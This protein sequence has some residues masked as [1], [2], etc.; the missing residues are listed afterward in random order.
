MKHPKKPPSLKEVLEELTPDEQIELFS[1]S[2]PVNSEYHHW[3][4]LRHLGPPE[5]LTNKQ[6][7]CMLKLQ[8]SGQAR[9]VPLRDN[10]G[11]AFTYYQTEKMSKAVHEIDLG[12]GGSIG[13]PEPVMNENTKNYYYVNSLIQ[14]AIT[15]S[16]LE[17]AAVTR[18]VAKEMIQSNR[19]PLGVDERMIVNNYR[20]MERLSEWKEMALTPVL[21]MEI[22]ELMTDGT[23]EKPD[24]SGRLRN[25]GEVVEIVDQRDGEVM[26]S[27]PDASELP[28]R[29]Q[30]LCDF[31][32][33]ENEEV[34]LH[35]VIKAIILHFWLAYD[36]P[37]V[38][39]N[40]RTARAIFYWYVLRKGFWLFEFLSISQILVKAPIQYGRSFLLTESDGND[41][42]YFIHAQLK[43]IRR[44]IKEMHSY[45]ESKSEEVQQVRGALLKLNIPLNHR[46]E[47]LIQKAVKEKHAT[48][49][50]GSHQKSHGIAYGTA[51]SDLLK[52][53]ELGLLSSQ[54][55]AK[56]HLYYPAPDLNEK[57]SRLE[58]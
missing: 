18:E 46:Q 50:V 29:L 38:D 20:T 30:A 47:A 57:L 33:E 26:H 44:S 45:I 10:R 11:G 28:A 36:H 49:S 48:F 51:R 27:P 6:W 32:N 14:E 34:F 16:Q 58:K 43:V 8:R 15:S 9:E 41:L 5:E 22:H 54:K 31:A 2:L 7:W 4:K 55:L 37:F 23:M 53:E 52:L 19:K 3:D 39:G 56:K 21:V 1:K 12:A 42:N 35:P 24:A 25:A 40:G 17:G 13:V